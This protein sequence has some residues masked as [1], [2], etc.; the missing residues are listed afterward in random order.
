M[1]LSL[2]YLCSFSYFLCSLYPNYLQACKRAIQIL[3]LHRYLISLLFGNVWLFISFKSNFTKSSFC[4]AC[5]GS[6]MMS[7]TKYIKSPLQFAF[8]QTLSIPNDSRNTQSQ[9]IKSNLLA[10]IKCCNEYFLNE[11]QSI[12][13]SAFVCNSIFL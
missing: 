1:A 2:F 5:N 11:S 6:T 7:D 8:I 10:N 4:C 9:A 13:A 3:N 12:A